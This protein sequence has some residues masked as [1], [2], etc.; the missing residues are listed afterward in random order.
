MYL[1]RLGFR[2]YQEAYGLQLA[3]VEARAA[4]RCPDVL[5][6]VEHP[7]VIT[8]GRAGGRDHLLVP[9]PT[10]QKAGIQLVPIDRGGNITYHGP[11]QLVGYPIMD[12]RE[13]DRDLHLLLR[14]YEEVFIR[15]LA[16]YDLKGQR[17]EGLTGVWIGDDKILAI[18][19]GVKRWISYHGFA[20]NIDPALEHFSYI[21]PCGLID[22]GVTSLARLL[23]RPVDVQG[24]EERVIESF[25]QVFQVN[26][27]PVDLTELEK[28]AGLELSR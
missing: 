16:G 18:G 10:L 22:K 20:F 14:N 6:L 2:D 9:V 17:Q 8:I 27:Q 25:R 7:P 1:V 12:L 23:G 26:L 11:G 4:G 13:R 19:V 28:E 15:V 24:V 3:L 21:H 5:L